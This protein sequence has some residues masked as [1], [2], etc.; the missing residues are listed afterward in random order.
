MGE[1]ELG[2]A[3]ARYALERFATPAGP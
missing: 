2:D 3:M 1:S